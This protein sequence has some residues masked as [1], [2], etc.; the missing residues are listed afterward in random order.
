MYLWNDDVCQSFG[1]GVQLLSL[2]K[3]QDLLI[4]LEVVLDAVVDVRDLVDIKVTVLHL[5]ILL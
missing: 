5:E 1:A 3:L 4:V 2:V